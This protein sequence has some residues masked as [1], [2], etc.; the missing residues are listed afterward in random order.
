MTGH[1]GLAVPDVYKACE[2]FETL[3]VNF[4]KKPDD[5]KQLNGAPLRFHRIMFH[6]SVHL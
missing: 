4:I 3:G 5:G 2:R 1:I 6:I